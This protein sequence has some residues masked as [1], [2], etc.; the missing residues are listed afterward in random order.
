MSRLA[1]IGPEPGETHAGLW[2]QRGLESGS[3]DPSKK[4]V[5]LRKVQ[6]LEKE[7]PA[8]GAFFKRW[9]DALQD[10]RRADGSGKTIALKLTCLDRLVV[11]LG[12]ESVV[13]TSITLH[14]TF[15]VPYLP[16]SALKGVAA[17]RAAQLGGTWARDGEAFRLL[18]GHAGDETGQSGG[19][20]FHDALPQPGGW[21]FAADTITVH[22]PSYYVDGSEPP[23]DWDAPIPVPF[24][25]CKGTFHLF[26]TG[27][28]AWLDRATE[29]LADA[30]AQDG[31][32]AKTALGYG[33]L[34][35]EGHPARVPGSRSSAL[36]EAPADARAPVVPPQDAVAEIRRRIATTLKANN[37]A[38]EVPKLLAACPTDRRSEVARL[39]EASLTR[40]WLAGRKEKDWVQELMR[41]L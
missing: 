39:I 37:A 26:L 3:T 22:H 8:Y 17:R 7:G 41:Y 38:Q 10:L 21:S 5:H 15:G 12:A 23:T 29:L 9:S 40:K 28:P 30:L 36:A 33:R 24:L 6:T 32:G 20:L 16:G 19:V 35:I 13:E 2:H 18:F 14:Q 11:G 27:L 25:V 1:N 4:S 34:D 31:I